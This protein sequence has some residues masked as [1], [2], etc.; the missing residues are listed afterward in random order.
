MWHAVIITPH[1]V[2]VAELPDDFNSLVPEK[3]LSPGPFSLM[4]QTPVYYFRSQL[5]IHL[6]MII[7]DTKIHVKGF[8]PNAHPKHFY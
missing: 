8:W 1:A 4:G 6:F 2:F 3:S 7:Y 5:F